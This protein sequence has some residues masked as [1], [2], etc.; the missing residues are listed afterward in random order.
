MLSLSIME[1]IIE[2]SLT[3]RHFDEGKAR[4]IHFGEVKAYP[5]VKPS[6][7]KVQASSAISYRQAQR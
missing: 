4:P 7:V 2:E 3:P 1:I 5:T 6:G